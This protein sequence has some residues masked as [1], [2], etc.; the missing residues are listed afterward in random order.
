MTRTYSIRSINSIT[1][2]ITTKRDVSLILKNKR[3]RRICNNQLIVSYPVRDQA[4][5]GKGQSRIL[6]LN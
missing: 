4:R 2:V 6:K 5:R 1:I 3:S